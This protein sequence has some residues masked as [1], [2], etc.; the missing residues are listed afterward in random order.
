VDY[1]RRILSGNFALLEGEINMVYGDGHFIRTR[2]LCRRDTYYNWYNENP[3]LN[4]G[5]I[6]IVTN[7]PDWWRRRKTRIKV[8]DGKTCFRDLK[9]V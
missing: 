4:N 2:Y 5:E 7:I 8:G 9:Y 6:I 1:K 3:I